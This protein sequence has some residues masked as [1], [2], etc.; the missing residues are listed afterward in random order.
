MKK[1]NIPN[2]GEILI[3]NIIFDINGTI[4]FQGRI[5]DE[6]VK[7]FQEIKQIYNIYLISADTRGNLKELAEKLGVKYIKINPIDVSEAE[8]KNQELEKLGKNETIAIGNGN[9]DSLMLKNALFG[10]LLIGG[11]GAT[12][13]SLL[14]SDVIFTDPI[15]IIDFLK[16]EKAIIGTL[17]S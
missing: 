5:S 9:N 14:N 8:A 16:D 1:I 7:K 6:I 3:K 11:E 15:D 13:K 17:R 2:Y 12:T 10:I 4:Q